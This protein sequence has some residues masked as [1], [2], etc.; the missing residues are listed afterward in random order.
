MATMKKNSDWNLLAVFIPIV[1]PILTFFVYNTYNISLGKLSRED[2]IKYLSNV[3]KQQLSCCNNSYEMDKKVCSEILKQGVVLGCLEKRVKE[4]S[5]QESVECEH[6]ADRL[7]H[8]CKSSV[9]DI[10]SERLGIK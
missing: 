6:K 4:N 5:Y 10:T 2:V 3:E 8:L 9:L 1:G 7:Y